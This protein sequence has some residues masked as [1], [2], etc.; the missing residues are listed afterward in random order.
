MTEQTAHSAPVLDLSTRLAV[1]RTRVAYERTMMAW[2]RTATSLITFGFTIYKFFQLE[3]PPPGRPNR[4][5]GPRGFA[6]IL[7][8]IG[9]FSL[10]LA[11]LEHRQNIRTLGDEYGVRRRSLAVLVAALIS[12]LGLLALAVIVFR[13]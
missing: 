11:T 13:Q 1:D 4:L 2:I 3:V 6:F 12:L 10:I 9:L 5:I 8:S 7:V